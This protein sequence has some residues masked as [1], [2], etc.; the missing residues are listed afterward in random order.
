M[1]TLELVIEVPSCQRWNYLLKFMNLRWTYE[2]IYIVPHPNSFRAYPLLKVTE[3]MVQ[4]YPK[5]PYD[6]C[7]VSKNRYERI[8]W[9]VALKYIFVSEV[10]T[11]TI[12]F[13]FYEN[14][15]MR[16]VLEKL[17]WC[18]A[19]AIPYRNLVCLSMSDLLVDIRHWR[20][21]VMTQF[22][23]PQSRICV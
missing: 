7:W 20:V 13:S 1:I 3:W 8:L 14:I 17:R 22:F 5:F 19:F 4:W 10:F 6:W 16:I 11:Q 18:K 23:N 21:K 15:F 2:S 12:W 9:F